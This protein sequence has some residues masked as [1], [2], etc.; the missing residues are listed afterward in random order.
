NRLETGLNQL[1]AP[2]LWRRQGMK[3][4]VR[5]WAVSFLNPPR[6]VCDQPAPGF[7]EHEYQAFG[8][9]DQGHLACTEILAGQKQLRC[10]CIAAR[11]AIAASIKRRRSVSSRRANRSEAE[12]S[13]R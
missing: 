13:Q 6:A 2:L 4:R 3:R 1:P 11:P 7:L 10:T 9:Q 8:R 5:S 12:T